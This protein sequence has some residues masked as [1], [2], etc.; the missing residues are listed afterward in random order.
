MDMFASKSY[1]AILSDM[2]TW[3]IA[4][5]D[6][7]TD[8]NEGAV[9]T[10]ICE[11]IAQEIE[12]LYLRTKIGF[13][14]YLP[15][16]P[17]YAFGFAHLIGLKSTGTVAFARNV[18]TA[19]PVTIPI[20][21]LVS[22]ASG[23]IFVTTA[24]GTILA[25]QLTSG[26]V[27]IEAQEV[28]ATYNVAA[29]TINVLTTPL[30]GVDTVNNG[31]TTTAGLDAEDANTFLNRFHAYVLGLG[32]ASAHGLETA[33]LSVNGVRSASSVEH[34]P[35]LPGNYYN[36]SMYIDDGAGNAPSQMVADVLLEIT[37]DGT[38]AHPG[39]KAAGINVE[40]IAP[41]KVTVNVAVQI[42][43]D[44]SVDRTT[45]TSNIQTAV[46]AYIN[47]LKLH[48]DVI[49]NEI[50]DSTMDVGGVYDMVLQNPLANVSI[51][52]SQIARVGAITVTY[53]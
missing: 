44:G 1:R 6:K 21:T 52:T 31:T 15:D 33:A 2:E 47:G 25:N 34:F 37:G 27:A 36:V 42:V 51:G 28:G 43:D 8:F 29:N 12:Q 23:L 49:I 18:A 53:L 17:F 38:A 22:T 40:V 45:I 35:P 11:A 50:I 3:I 14:K 20:S 32:K 46:A 10:S 24:L 9:S 26:D 41:T 13:I 39:Y 4:N 48:Q 19:N 7:I 30:V 16:L 5:Q